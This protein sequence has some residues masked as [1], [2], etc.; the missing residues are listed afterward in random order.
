MTSKGRSLDAFQKRTFRATFA[1][2]L[3][4]SLFTKV[5]PLSVYVTK[6]VLLFSIEFEAV[7]IMGRSSLLLMIK[8]R[9]G[10]LT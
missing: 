3:T 8:N 1:F 4:L 7:D 2:A 6:E 10:R 9:K 5:I